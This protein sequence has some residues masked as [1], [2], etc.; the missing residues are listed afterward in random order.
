MKRLAIAA[1]AALFF[2]A[3]AA[4]A[5]EVSVSVG[6]ELKRHEKAY[7]ADEI[8]SLKKELADD[9]QRALAKRGAVPIQRVD[10]VLESAT[11][12]RP[13]FNELS[14]VTSLSLNSIG[15]G[16][17]AITGTVTRTDGVVESVS[18]TWHETDLRQVIGYTTWTDAGLAFDR[19]ASAIAH[20]KTPNGR[21]YHPDLASTAAFDSLNRFR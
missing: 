14:A 13:T 17:A 4:S 15:L 11:P 3:G 1:A 21:P 5:A 9:I 16:G 2:T 19:L 12:N 7:G 6:P 8:A 20:G 18:Y 10:L